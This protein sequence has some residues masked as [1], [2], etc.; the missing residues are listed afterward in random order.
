MPIAMSANRRRSIRPDK[1]GAATVLAIMLL[2]IGGQ[3]Q[4]VAQS[5]PADAPKISV[6]AM[7]R[8]QEAQL[9]L[10]SL[11]R[12]G[13]FDKAEPLVRQILGRFPTLPF[14]NFVA[15]VLAARKGDAEGAISLLE[16][17]LENGFRDPTALE[18]TPIF[19][20][21]RN[22]PRFEAVVAEMK[23]PAEPRDSN[24]TKPSPVQNGVAE[25]GEDNTGWDPRLNLLESSFKFSSKLFASRIVDGGKDKP[26]D[27]L[28]DLYR[29]G[30][31]A[32]NLGDLYDNRDRGHSP[33]PQTLLPQVAMVKYGNGAKASGLDYGFNSKLFF[34]APAF[35]NS[36]VGVKGQFSVARMAMANPRETGI[37][38]LQ[39]RKNQLYIY[40]SV[41][42]FLAKKGDAFTANTPYTLVSLGKS[43]SDKPFLHA[44][45]NIMAAF[46]PEVKKALI[47]RSLLMPVVQ[48]VFRRGLK[49]VDSDSD[50]LSGKAHP[51]V[52]DGERIDRAKM[53]RLANAL[54][55]ADIPPM[56]SLSV[57]E[58]S[59]VSVSKP[60]QNPNGIVFNTPSALGRV[61][62]K[63]GESK[64]ITVDASETGG[65]GADG[66]RY[67]W[68]V[69][70]G[71]KDKI[72]ISPRA[73]GAAAEITVPWHGN[74]PSI[75][76]PDVKTNRVDIGVFVQA[77]S[78]ISAPAIISIFNDPSG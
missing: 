21:I 7:P 29:S 52:F 10:A 26:A 50:Y 58:E 48:M 72:K 43:R 33:L 45:G 44:V 8:A 71:D 56:V 54:D 31:A 73:D 53:I 69:L 62:F 66:I 51:V 65:E 75:N 12:S 64:R 59:A 60:G 18:K 61:V 68:V 34:N 5:G 37:L 32:G 1:R 46:K 70:E 57:V 16:T 3:G 78:V 38:Y 47:E 15:A 41:H 4:A 74:R 42:D 40:P 76:A 67:H 2:A 11:V 19:N 14:P 35:G 49:G 23:S 39:Y 63:A 25:V 17:A 77:G 27:L 55:V 28:N 22:N 13:D 20:P 30:K 9:A 24:A 6:F 36:S